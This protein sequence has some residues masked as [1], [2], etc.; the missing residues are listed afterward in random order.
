MHKTVLYN[1]VV[2]FASI[3][4]I[5]RMIP[6]H[7]LSVILHVLL[8]GVRSVV[9]T[10][11]LELDYKY[12]THH[13]LINIYGPERWSYAYVLCLYPSIYDQIMYVG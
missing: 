10:R 11:V 2:S 6:G 5:I 4:Y 3:V 12:N 8:V 13:S 7:E 1:C 9:G